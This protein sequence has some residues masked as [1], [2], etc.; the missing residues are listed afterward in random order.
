MPTAAG[1]NA[2]PSAAKH[3]GITPAFRSL[4]SHH[5]NG[6]R[7][8]ESGIR[9]VQLS[10]PQRRLAQA[11]KNARE[12]ALLPTP[13]DSYTLQRPFSLRRPHRADGG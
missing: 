5:A 11:I 7:S 3:N 8:L 12:M 9:Q 10:P 4:R 1:R 13:V 6:R 2:R